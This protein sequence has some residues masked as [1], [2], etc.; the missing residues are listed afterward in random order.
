[1]VAVVAVYNNVES[2]LDVLSQLKGADLPVIVVDDGSDDGTTEVIQ[3]WTDREGAPTCRVCRLEV[4]S[5]KAA[6]MRQGFKWARE[7]DYTHALTFDADGHPLATPRPAASCA[8]SAGA[9]GAG[10]VS[11]DFGA[12]KPGGHRPRLEVTMVGR[13]AEPLGPFRLGV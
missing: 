6:A 10:T 1:M 5:G 7:L 9:L 12:A 8:D 3:S 13:S 2:I 11:V 4:N